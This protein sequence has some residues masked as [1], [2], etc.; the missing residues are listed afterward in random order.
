MTT[1]GRQG[2]VARIDE[3]NASSARGRPAPRETGPLPQLRGNN[4][5]QSWIRPLGESR[6]IY[7]AS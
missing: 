3:E 5:D 6:S 1:R 2:D 7:Q 4:A